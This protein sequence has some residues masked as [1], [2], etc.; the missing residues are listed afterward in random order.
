MPVD[1]EQQAATY[2]RTRGA[3]PTIVRLLVKYLGPP[4]GRSVADVAGGTGNYAAVLEARG[5]RP[6]VVERARAMAL[7]ARKKLPP[8]SV[9]IGD[10]L[11]L[12][13]WDAAVDAAVLVSALH[14]FADQRRALS[15]VRRVIRDGPFV[16]MAFTRESLLTTFV[17]EYFP[18][19]DPPASMH[20]PA[21]EIEVALLGAGFARVEEEPFVYVDTA[22][23][24]L[25]ALHTD[26]L[27]LAGPAY[28]RNTSFFHRL[29]EDVREEGLARLAADL[30]SGRLEERVRESFALAAVHGHGSVFA[31]WPGE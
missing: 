27:S 23:G 11:A 4:E 9:V 25:H 31:A 12:P 16:L 2:D 6:V 30:R 28:L 24:S 29:P 5:F 15:E 18:G 17:F 20:L 10:A 22:D 13:L 14:Q 26:A 3:S 21:A 8:G 1:Y 19:S 7:R